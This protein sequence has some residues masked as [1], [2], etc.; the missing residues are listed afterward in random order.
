MSKGT[1]AMVAWT[2]DNR[3]TDLSGTADLDQ[4][5]T[6]NAANEITDLSG[7]ANDLTHDAAGNMTADSS[8]TYIYDAW[9]RLVEV[10]DRGDDSLIAEYEY[11]GQKRRIEKTVNSSTDDYFYNSGWQLVETRTADDADPAEQYVWDLRYVDAPVLRFQDTNTDG[12]VDNTLY[13]T[14][15]ANFNVT[16]LVD[17]SGTVVER[18]AYSPYGERTVLDADWSADADGLSDVDNVLGHQGL[19]L[20]TE[21]ALYYNR[22]RYYSPT[23][24]RFITRDPLGYIDGMSV[25]EYVG[26]SAVNTADPEGLHP[27]DRDPMTSLLIYLQSEAA[28]LGA[29]SGNSNS[30]ETFVYEEYL[31]CYCEATTASEKA[32][33]AEKAIGEMSEAGEGRVWKHGYKQDASK[34]RQGMIEDYDDW[35]SPD[36]NKAGQVYW[37]SSLF[38]GNPNGRLPMTVESADGEV[39]WFKDVVWN[40]PNMSQIMHFGAGIAMAGLPEGLHQWLNIWYETDKAPEGWEFMGL[41]AINDVIAVEAGGAFGRALSECTVTCGD[42]FVD[43]DPY[44]R[45]GRQFANRHITVN[46]INQFLKSRANCAS[47]AATTKQG[48]ES[49]LFWQNPVASQ[50]RAGQTA[51]T[52]AASVEGK[53]AIELYRLAM[54][55]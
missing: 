40:G 27:R 22:N 52:I 24:G 1:S 26:S 2:F 44:L 12:T 31:K 51:A 53:W 3:S 16:A 42:G 14:N 33:E 18:Y 4:T 8:N 13:Y 17:E 20:D 36:R 41:D 23:L 35:H 6:H 34:L 39:E 46:R 10:R 5:R 49:I 15:D 38:L 7:T 9:N 32:K 50:R 55:P 54:Y 48:K 37:A 11:D 43:L 29:P 25:Y 30:F 21:S 19:H 47:I 28:K 45:K